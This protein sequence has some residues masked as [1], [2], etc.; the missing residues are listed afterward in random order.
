[1]ARKVILSDDDSS[2]PDSD[3]PVLPH[4]KSK[5][6][7]KLNLEQAAA[8]A[9]GKTARKCQSTTKVQENEHREEE[10]QLATAHKKH[11]ETK[12]L[13]RER[14]RDR[15]PPES[16]DE[17]DDPIQMSAFSDSIRKPPFSSHL[18]H[19]SGVIVTTGVKPL[20]KRLLRKSG[21]EIIPTP[22]TMSRRIALRPID[23]NAT[24]DQDFSPMPGVEE[25]P[26]QSSSPRTSHH[27][28]SLSR[29][30]PLPSSSP[31]PS[32][33]QKRIHRSAPPRRRSPSPNP[34]PRKRSKTAA[35]ATDPPAKVA[36]CT[37]GKAPTGSRT[38]LKNFTESGRKLIQRAM[39]EYEIRICTV[40]AY[41]STELQE[42]WVQEIW[43]GA[44]ADAQE[45][46][47]LTERISRMIKLYASHARS[48]LKDGIW[49]LVGPTYGFNA[50]ETKQDRKTNVKLQ[51]NLLEDSAF[52]Y[53]DPDELNMYAGHPIIKAILR[54]IFFKKGGC[55]VKY[56]KYF[57]PI[58][59]VTLALIFTLLSR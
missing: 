25:E 27:L 56:S 24:E 15:T 31:H 12:A 37:D 4:S 55:G 45:P 20:P 16:E 30:S 9:N 14:D 43:D 51:N 26:P 53:Q 42:L 52:H 21:E 13:L 48:S 34:R 10:G 47:A 49:P 33:H 59:L 57:S 3:A 38:Y 23:P 7:P 54:R 8:A 29:T 40:D 5:P 6:L 19:P 17:P 22:G 41:P 35:A 44:N 39:H 1:M 18:S 50:G 2:G 28:S 32:Q 46:T 58:L 11:E 36:E